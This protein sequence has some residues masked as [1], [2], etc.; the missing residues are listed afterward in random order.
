MSAWIKGLIIGVS[1]AAPVGPIGLLCIRQ[2]LNQGR[3]FGFVSGMGAATADACY[4]LVAALGLTVIAQFLTDQA[5]WLNMIG[6]A[7]LF[8]LAYTTA[9]ASVFDQDRLSQSSKGYWSTYGTTLFLTLT[10]PLTIISFAGIF[11]G[12]NI[13]EGTDASLWLVLG[14]F[15]GSALWWVLLSVTVGLLKRMINLTALKWINYAS[16]LILLGFGLY[17]LYQFGIGIGGK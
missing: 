10:N 15:M 12:M 17:S 6:S 5:I 13:S 2:T 11:A 9:R 14:V 7:F 16:A 3:R 8:Y 4:G 1:I